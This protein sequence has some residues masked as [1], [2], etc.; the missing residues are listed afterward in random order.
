M[1]SS[2]TIEVRCAALGIICGQHTAAS[3]TVTEFTEAAIRVLN[4]AVDECIVVTSWRTYPVAVSIWSL[5]W[6]GHTK[7]FA[8][9]ARDA[10]LEAFAVLR[11]H[12][13]DTN[14]FQASG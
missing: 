8:N 4:A 12:T 3:S 2:R 5:I 9:I 1:G 7:G 13:F 14:I 10:Y 11:I 6:V